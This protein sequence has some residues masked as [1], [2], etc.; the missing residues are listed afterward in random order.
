[1]LFY[2]FENLMASETEA[3]K[4]LLK[5]IMEKWSRFIYSKNADIRVGQIG[6]DGHAGNGSVPRYAGN[7]DIALAIARRYEDKTDKTG[8]DRNDI[9]RNGQGFNKIVSSFAEGSASNGSDAKKQVT[10]RVRTPFNQGFLF[11][12]QPEMKN[13]DKRDVLEKT[14][15]ERRSQLM[16]K[17]IDSGRGS[18]KGLG[19]KSNPRYM[20]SIYK[21]F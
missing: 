21:C 7:D 6:P 4:R 2:S 12:V 18:S 19:K 11:T 16:K 15:G 10:N 13:I 3:N 5:Q 17:M 14:W 20:L 9:D 1:M 8:K